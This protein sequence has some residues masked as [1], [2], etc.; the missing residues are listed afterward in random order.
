MSGGKI[1]ISLALLGRGGFG[2]LRAFVWGKGLPSL[3][4]QHHRQHKELN[5]NPLGVSPLD[6]EA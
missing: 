6:P 2:P 4:V 5:S 1:E 3:P